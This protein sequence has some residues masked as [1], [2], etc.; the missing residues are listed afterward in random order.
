MKKLSIILVTLGLLISCQAQEKIIYTKYGNIGEKFNYNDEVYIK[1]KQEVIEVYKGLVG[2]WKATEV[3]DLAF[4]VQYEECLFSGNAYYIDECYADNINH[5]DFQTD[6]DMMI[7]GT[8]YDNINNL[9]MIFFRIGPS[10]FTG[11]VN[12]VSVSGFLH[13]IDDNTLRMEI[14]GVQHSSADDEEITIRADYKIETAPTE[15]LERVP[16]V[17]RQKTL[18]FKRQTTINSP[19]EFIRP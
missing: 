9:K 11:G 1:N 15:I 13:V 18:T 8:G 3:N 14:M 17:L 7:G 4:R 10:N 12:Q 6:F 2:N 5:P 16:A 19:K